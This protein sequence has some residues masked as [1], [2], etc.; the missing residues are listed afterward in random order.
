MGSGFATLGI[1][2]ELIVNEYSLTITALDVGCYMRNEDL[3]K[4]TL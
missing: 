2:T 4:A 1:I 3:L